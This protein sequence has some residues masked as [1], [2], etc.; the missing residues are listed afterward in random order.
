LIFKKLTKNNLQKD[1]LEFDQF[2]NGMVIIA[3]KIHPYSDL[4]TALDILL[5]TRFSEIE[6]SI[7]ATE[8]GDSSSQI[9]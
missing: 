8:R 3:S 5:S 4:Q 7:A 9:T 6:E 1:R 2:F